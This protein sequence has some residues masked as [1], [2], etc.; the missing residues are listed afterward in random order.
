MPEL[1]SWGRSPFLGSRWV[2][3]FGG[4]WN[5]MRQ[6]LLPL[7]NLAQTGSP[8]AA[9]TLSRVRTLVLL[10]AALSLVVSLA[11]RTFDN[12]GERHT[13]VRSG[14][15]QA[16]H[17]HLDR[18]SVTWTVPVALFVPP[19]WRAVAAHIPAPSEPLVSLEIYSSLYN[20]PPPSC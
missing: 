7:V 1:P 14:S 9:P 16:K 15:H 11:G 20:R 19:L 18:D 12:E 13:S 4:E 8:F 17:K 3:L 5:I 6:Q 10:F 2:F